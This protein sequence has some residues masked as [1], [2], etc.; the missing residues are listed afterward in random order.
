MALINCPECNNQISDKSKYC[1]HCGYPL[2]ETFE[3]TQTYA[4]I[5][6][7]NNNS[8]TRFVS[9]TKKILHVSNQNDWDSIFD[10]I[11]NEKPILQKLTLDDANRIKQKF[12]QE[13]INLII[14]EDEEL[15]AKD[16]V[17]NLDI[18]TNLPKCPMCGSTNIQKI[19]DLS[20]TSSILGF[21][22]LSKKIGKQWQCNNPKCKH[23]W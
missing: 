20:R 18:V 10:K 4:L 22:I 3:M 8:L 6:D 2:N 1:I 13:N 11:K 17:A 12:K 15:R 19:S 14:I 21:G 9:A 23:L 5:Y 16:I 7:K